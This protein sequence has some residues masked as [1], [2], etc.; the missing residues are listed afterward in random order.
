[1]EDISYSNTSSPPPGERTTVPQN[2]WGGMGLKDPPVP[3]PAVGWAATHKATADTAGE[4][5]LESRTRNAQ[6]KELRPQ[7]EG[8]KPFGKNPKLFQ[9]H[10]KLIVLRNCILI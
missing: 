10:F 9:K 2:G 8:F 3:T 1:M 4:N 5:T 6:N 7:T